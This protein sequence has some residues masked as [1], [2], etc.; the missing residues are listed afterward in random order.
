ML[1][2]QVITLMDPLM[3]V[4]IWAQ[5]VHIHLLLDPLLAVLLMLGDGGDRLTVLLCADNH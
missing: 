3:L 1:V 4:S 2:L 5:L